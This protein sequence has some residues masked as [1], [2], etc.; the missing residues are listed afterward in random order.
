M[1]IDEYLYIEN[2]V[3]YKRVSCPYIIVEINSYNNNNNNNNKFND[4]LGNNY[5]KVINIINDNNNFNNEKSYY[6]L[7]DNN[8]S[9]ALAHW[10]YESFIYIKLLIELNKI[11]NNIKILTK[12]NKKYVKSMLKFFNINNIVVNKI[13]NYNNITYSPLYFPICNIINPDKNI[14]FNYHLN[15]YLDYIKNNILNLSSNNNLLFLPRNEI[16]NFEP[17][18]RKIEFT[19]KIKN[20]IIEKNGIVLDTYHLN[21]IKYQFS[22]IN[23][24]KTIILD[25]GSSFL[26]NCLFLENKNIYIIDNFGYYHE[27][28]QSHPYIKYIIDKIIEKN[29]IH[30]YNSK[31]L[32]EKNIIYL[33]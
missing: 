33:L 6:F 9:P 23:D 25:Y 30:I 1:D 20:I 24:A 21:N 19:D 5:I 27:Q 31:E 12:N 16:D 7:L 14:Y 22:I 18:D 32:I 15:F 13:D 28:R 2:L 11:N 4:K 29:N 26:F 10:I 3:D 8:E 17:L